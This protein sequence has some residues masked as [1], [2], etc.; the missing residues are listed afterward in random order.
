MIAPWITDAALEQKASHSQ[1]EG[2]NVGDLERLLSL[3][4]GG[5]L[6]LCGATRGTLGGLGLALLGGALMYRGAT[7]Q[8]PCYRALGIN[9]SDE[10]RGPATSVPAGAGVKLEKAFTVNRS[11]AELF[12]FWRN[13]ENLPRFMQHLESVTILSST[14]SHWVA[15]G[16]LGLTVQWEAEI[17]NEKP[18]DMI[19]WRSRAGSDVDTAGSVHFTPAPGGTEVRVVLKYDPPAGKVGAALAR[20]FGQAPEQ[21]IHEDLRRFKQIMEAG[22]MTSGAF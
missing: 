21:Q 16:P 18:N 7:G 12:R 10:A 2:R 13:F 1:H 19:A 17:H 20:L 15:K 11:A 4:G 9:T 3:L 5:G 6:A 8:C 14:R 22:A